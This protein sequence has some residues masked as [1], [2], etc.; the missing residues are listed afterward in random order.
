MLLATI[1]MM[2]AGVVVAKED[3]V[4]DAG[5]RIETVVVHNQCLDGANSVMLNNQSVV[6]YR[7]TVLKRKEFDEKITKV[8]DPGKWVWIGCT[9]DGYTYSISELIKL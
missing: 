3:K 6:K 7:I 1:F 2:H 5:V 9:N 4:V 8:L